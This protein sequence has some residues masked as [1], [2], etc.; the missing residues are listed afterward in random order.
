[1]PREEGE[2]VPEQPRFAQIKA[3][4]FLLRVFCFFAVQVGFYLKPSAD[5]SLS[6][7]EC[8]FFVQVTSADMTVDLSPSD[9]VV[10]EYY[11]KLNQYREVGSTHERTVRAAFQHLL[12]HVGKKR[13]WTLVQEHYMKERGIRV[14]GAPSKTPSTSTTATGRRRTPTTTSARR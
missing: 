10:Q 11:N 1:M 7:R 3:G 4:S 6:T 12:E 13:G 9:D 2:R 8:R 5:K 14:D